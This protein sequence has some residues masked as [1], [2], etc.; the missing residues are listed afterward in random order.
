MEHNRIIEFA[1][2][3]VN[4]SLDVLGVLENGY[5]EVEMILQEIDLADDIILEPL[6]SGIELHCDVDY[7][8][9]DASNL[10]WRAADLVLKETG[11]DKGVRITIVKRIPVAA[12]LAGGSADAA[13]VIRGLNRL[14]DLNLDLE[15]QQRIGLSLGADVPFCITGGCAV[16]RGIGEK[17]EP[18]VGFGSHWVVLAKP[19]IGVSTPAVYQR[20]DQTV[21]EE[22]PDT[23]ALIQAIRTDQMR[24]VA[25]HM[26]NVLEPVTTQMHPIVGKIRN[27][28]I[29]YGSDGAMMSG[30]G[31]TVFGFFRQYDRAMK[32]CK[33]LKKTYAQ[34]YLARTTNRAL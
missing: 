21:I 1:Y 12:G 19:N 31:P 17:L 25:E 4:L 26:V 27:Q 15:T 30:S 9:L 2:A 24:Y 22:R 23:P 13:A 3:K 33:N 20:Y 7:L 10:A 29:Q 5:H 18:L 8:P 6:E 11:L 28:L 14:Y 16:A 32:A 34:V